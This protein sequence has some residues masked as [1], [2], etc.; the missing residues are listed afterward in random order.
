VRKNGG[1]LVK[2]LGDGMVCQFKEPDGAFRAA[3]E[4]QTVAVDI[5]PQADTKLSIKIGFTW[6]PVVAEGGDVFGDTVNVCARV[7]SLANPQQVLTTQETID[8]LSPGLRERSRALY[9][10]KVRG[11]V[12][13]VKVCE[14]I[15]RTGDADITKAFTRSG[16]VRAKAAASRQ[17]IL[18]VTYAGE[19]KVVEGSASIKLGRD[20]SNDVVVNSN[21]AS[22]VHA[23]ISGRGDKFVIADQSS[24]GTFVMIDGHSREIR[25]RREEATLGERGYIGLGG[26]ASSHGEHVLRYRLES[27]KA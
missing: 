9:P 23:R 3:C 8:A 1:R 26:P 7:V 6:G 5:E 19:T 15:W 13:E 24:N 12:G 11:R 20:Q 22:R 17:Y 27:R 18:K 14:V 10:L 4:M 2:T 25:L 16:L 21:L